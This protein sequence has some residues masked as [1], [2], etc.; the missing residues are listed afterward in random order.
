MIGIPSNDGDSGN[1]IGTAKIYKWNSLEWVQLGN[2]IDGDD[3]LN[4]LG[5]SQQISKD[6]SIIICGSVGHS[7]VRGKAP[8]PSQGW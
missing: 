3:D 2:D 1:N 4:Y 5:H 6:G 8:L 7:M